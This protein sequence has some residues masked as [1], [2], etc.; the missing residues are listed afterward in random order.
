MFTEIKSS[1]HHKLK[2]DMRA[3]LDALKIHFP[4]V[5]ILRNNYDTILESF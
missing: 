2:I 5:N 1:N 4:V 3:V